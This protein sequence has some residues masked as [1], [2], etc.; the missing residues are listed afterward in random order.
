MFGRAVEHSTSDY[1]VLG[2]K[3]GVFKSTEVSFTGFH[4]SSYCSMPV[5]SLKRPWLLKKQG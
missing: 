4:P 1:W 5:P 3:A 2:L